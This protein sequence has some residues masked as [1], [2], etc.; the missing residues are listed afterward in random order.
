MI[1]IIDTQSIDARK[2]VHAYLCTD[3]FKLK[4]ENKV[5]YTKKGNKIY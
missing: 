4:M 3:K 2:A 5:H 1:T